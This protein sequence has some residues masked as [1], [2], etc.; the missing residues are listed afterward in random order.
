M[1]RTRQ[2]VAQRVADHLFAL[3]DAIDVALT[4]SAELNA[5]MP[6]ARG[7]ARLPAMIGQT[8]LDHAADTFTSLVQARRNVVETHRSL[9]EARAEIGLQEVNIGDMAPKPPPADIPYGHARPA[10]LRAVG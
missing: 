7:E 3:E 10:P 1:P 6:S 4:R 2:A 9:D 8:A 5:S